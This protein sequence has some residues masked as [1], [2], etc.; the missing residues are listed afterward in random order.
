MIERPSA[1][2]LSAPSGWRGIRGWL[3]RVPVKDPVDRRNA[4]MLQLVLLMLGSLPPLAWAYRI[5]VAP[6]PWRPGETFSLMLS[7]LLSALAIFSVVLIRRGRFQWAVRQFMALVALVMMLSYV[8][9]G[10]DANR[11]EQPIQMIWLVIS[12]LMIGRRALW[13]MYGWTVLTFA[14]GAWRDVEAKIAAATSTANITGDV[15]ISA[16]IFLFIAVVVDRSAAAL[17]ESL[18]EAT[19]RGD[20]LA[21]ANQRL[22]AEI[23]ERERVQHQLIH[24]QKVEA[25]GRLAGGVAHDFNHLLG[26]VLGYAQRG[27]RAPDEEEKQKALIGVESAARRA[28]AVSQKL[29]SFSRRDVA[30]PEVFDVSAALREMQGPLRQLFDPSVEIVFDLP[31]QSALI[32]FD[33]AQFELM[34]L[35]IAANANYAMPDGGSFHVAVRALSQPAR[36]AIELRDTGCGMDAETRAH[37]FEPFFTTKPRGQGTGLGLAVIHD[38]ILNSEGSIEVESSPGN[39]AEFFIHLPSV[40]DIHG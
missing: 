16:I 39:G 3:S 17:R 38:L 9:N 28:T 13:L 29:L 24:S 33:R 26:L 6:A 40:A 36:V 37:I 15:A 19:K 35:N 18:S 5:F 22:Q 23:A 1:F 27:Q 32:H 4:P 30:Q 8:G 11:F 25:V 10:F 14:V 34:I 7:L 20:Q 21:R 2:R 31:E 12:G